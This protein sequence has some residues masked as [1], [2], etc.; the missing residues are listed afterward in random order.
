[1]HV[2][3]RVRKVGR[4]VLYVHMY[5]QYLIDNSMSRTKAQTK[6]DPTLTHIHQVDFIF[7]LQLHLP[8]HLPLLLLIIL[9]AEYIAA[10]QH[11]LST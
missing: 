7:L 4:K 11:R 5:V 3:K 8:L 9:T 1:M 10:A 2:G 6:G